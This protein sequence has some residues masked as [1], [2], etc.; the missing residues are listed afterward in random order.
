M[1]ND[2]VPKELDQAARRESATLTDQ[3]GRKWQAIIDTI[4]RGTCSAVGP[5]N[6]TDRLDT[7]Q[8]Y[9]RADT[10][11]RTLH[12][13][14]DT[15]IGDLEYA[16]KLYDDQLRDTALALFGENGPKM[17]E[18][19]A[20]ALM[21]H[22]GEAPQPVEPVK[23]AR[24]GNRYC[25]GISDAMPL[26]AVPFFTKPLAPVEV[27]PDAEEEYLDVEEEADPEAMGGKR[28]NPRNLKGQ[29]LKGQFAEV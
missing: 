26:W 25:L 24:T 4:A 3:Y 1:P 9:L 7:P 14:F 15:W 20:P 13:D 5:K 8:K 2:F 23:A 12:V 27:F 22:V 6:F 11:E 29:F 17:Y 19:R 28:V 18:D 10:S 21:R 16:H